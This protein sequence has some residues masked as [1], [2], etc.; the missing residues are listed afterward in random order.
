[1]QGIFEPLG[2]TGGS[3]T[4][5]LATVESALKM[6]KYVLYLETKIANQV[7]AEPHSSSCFETTEVF[8]HS[9]LFYLNLKT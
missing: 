3:C 2:H 8:L 6:V 1:M 9:V 5:T 4:P 7:Q